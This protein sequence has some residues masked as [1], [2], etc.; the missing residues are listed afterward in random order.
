MNNFREWGVLGA[1][2]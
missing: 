2:I 1:G